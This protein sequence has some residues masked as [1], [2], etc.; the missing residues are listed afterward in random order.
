MAGMN[1]FKGDA[2]SMMS[3]MAAIKNV[4]YKPQYLGSLGLFQDKPQRTRVVAVEEKDGA[5]SIIQTSKLGA[6]LPQMGSDKARI[7][8]FRT[9]RLAK[10]STIYAHEIDGIREFGSETELKQVQVEVASRLQGL[11]DD[12]ELTWERHRL[13]AVQGVVLDADNSTIYNYF[14][15]FGIAQPDELGFDF[16]ALAAGE[17]RAFIEK[18]VVR[19]MARA[20]KGAMV[21]GSSIVALCGDDF[22]DKLVNHPEVRQT[23]LNYMA[24]VELREGTAFGAFRYAGVEWVNYR[25]TDDNTTVAIAADKVKFFPNAPGI[26]QVAWAPAEFMDATNRPGVPVTP[27]VLPDEKRNAFVEVEVYSYPLFICTRPKTLLRGTLG[28]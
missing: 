8:D 25:G 11:H 15:E 20:A 7:R 23:Y 24:A 18:Y 2:F 10:G 22:W 16:D 6:P 17:L 9:V 28:S 5:L 27:L 3:L 19:A 14:T 21:T 4:D 26:F 1:V 12:L 13:G